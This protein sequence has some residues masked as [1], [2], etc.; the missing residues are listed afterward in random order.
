V[1]LIITVVTP[2]AV[3]QVSDMQVTAFKDG[4]V[5][6][7]QQRK[8]IIMQG[9]QVVFVIGWTGLAT[10]GNHNTGEWLHRQLDAM[11]APSLP[12]ETIVKSLADSA[13]L[14]FATLPKMDKRSTFSLGGWFVTPINTVEPFSARITNCET[15]PVGTLSAT[16]SVKFEYG[17]GLRNP[18]K[19]PSK[20]PY[21]VTVTGDERTALELKTYWRG[22]RGL[23]KRLVD[24]SRI[25]SACRQIALA[26]AM[27]QDEKKK[28]DAH[29]V[30]TVGK[31]LLA[32]EMDSSG[33]S[34]CFFFPEDGSSTLVLAAD[35]VSAALS[36]KGVTMDRRLNK[37][38]NVEIM[39]KGWFKRN[40]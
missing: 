10:V 31:S 19:P 6:S 5:V 26:V 21:M 3:V 4:T 30:K 29:Y 16:A 7:G 13:T 11:N 25:S 38:G 9:S 22:L 34:Q 14:H 27:K 32:I 40:A 23:L 39:V 24:S 2:Y 36:T 15:D 17:F 37:D 12:L 1:S 8:S 20:H 28:K 35:I 18:K 33:A